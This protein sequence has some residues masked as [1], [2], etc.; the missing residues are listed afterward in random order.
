MPVTELP[1]LTTE[2]AFTEIPFTEMPVT[3]RNFTQIVHAWR[4]DDQKPNGCRR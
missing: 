4:A 2:I 3:D 1:S